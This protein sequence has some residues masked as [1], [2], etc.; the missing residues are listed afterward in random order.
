[1]NEDEEDQVYCDGD[2][3]P[4]LFVTKTMTLQCPDELKQR[5][6]LFKTKDRINGRSIKVIING[7]NCHNLA[8]EE[9]CTKIHLK[10]KWHPYPYQVQ[11]LSDSGTIKI[12]FTVDVSD[13]TE[14]RH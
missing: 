9:L 13:G 3:S 5:C 7:G 8:S 4:T 11:W 6:K 10:Y 14:D 12:K 1:M 2:P